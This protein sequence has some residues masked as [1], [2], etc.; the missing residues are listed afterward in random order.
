MWF[1]K[2]LI[3]EKIFDFYSKVQQDYEAMEQN[4]HLD[5]N[6]VYVLLNLRHPLPEDSKQLRDGG[7]GILKNLLALQL[8]RVKEGELWRRQKSMVL[9]E[10]LS[11]FFKYMNVKTACRADFSATD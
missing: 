5:A 6:D 7:V 1:K 4:C 2:K 11:L 8:T 3:N 10:E 9:Q